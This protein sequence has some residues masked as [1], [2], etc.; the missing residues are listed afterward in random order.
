MTAGFVLS[1]FRPQ[2]SP[3]PLDL[4]I[5]KS[6]P[7]VPEPAGMQRPAQSHGDT[8]SARRRRLLSWTRQAASSL[9]RSANTS[10]YASLKYLSQALGIPLLRHWLTALVL[11][12]QILATSPV[13]PSASMI[14]FGFMSA[15]LDNYLTD[16]K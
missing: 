2:T 5:K 13:P 8:Q 4:R 11:T 6:L 16:V 1:A 9:S 7:A 14:R 15:I 12:I 3:L 10:G